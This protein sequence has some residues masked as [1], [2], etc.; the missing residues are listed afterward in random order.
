MDAST[1]VSLPQY[2]LGFRK[3]HT[4]AIIPVVGTGY[5]AALD[6][7]ALFSCT[8][9]AGSRVEVRTGVALDFVIKNNEKATELQELVNFLSEE[10]NVQKVK[11]K[12][13]K[14]LRSSLMKS[15]PLKSNCPEKH[16]TFKE[17]VVEKVF[18]NVIEIKNER[19]FLKIRSRSGMAAKHNVNVV[20]HR[21][22]EAS[23][24]NRGEVIVS[25]INTGCKDFNLE[26]GMR[27]AQAVVH[28]GEAFQKEDEGVIKYRL[29]EE[30][31]LP[32]VME[33]RGIF[34]KM[35][36][37]LSKERCLVP[38]DSSKIVRT[39]VAISLPS[40]SCY[41]QLQAPPLSSEF[42]AIVNSDHMTVQAGVIDA[43]YRGEVAVVLRNDSNNQIFEIEP[44]TPLAMGVL[45]NVT[46]P[47]AR[48]IDATGAIEDYIK[49][50][51]KKNEIVKMSP[52][53][54]DVDE[55]SY[56]SLFVVR[57][58]ASS[59]LIRVQKEF[60]TFMN[61]ARVVK[62]GVCVN[63]KVL[64][65]TESVLEVQ[66]T[67]DSA[68]RVIAWDIDTSTGEIM[69]LVKPK[70]SIEERVKRG[71]ML[72]HIYIC[73]SPKERI[74]LMR[75]TELDTQDRGTGGFGSTGIF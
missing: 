58:C 59:Y 52:K 61:H 12:E 45:Y 30:T 7:H 60:K 37:F 53:F 29:L 38:P 51:N 39:G 49:I 2:C 68:V 71:E 42:Y 41:M 50:N 17:P 54:I 44:G 22:A 40:M 11:K 5:S 43:D 34:G 21:K 6:L 14:I 13:S 46:C 66:T 28:L 10:E 16:V 75:V 26:A 8:I 4:E 74:S 20:N 67:P 32:P 23:S 36:V 25:V 69:L 73:S 65:D 9:P 48:L 64:K 31:A 27:F 35:P 18:G 24:P 19:F 62:T 47:V 55:N 15:T 70:S 33:D 63:K 56:W 57:E 72:A 3:T 1:T